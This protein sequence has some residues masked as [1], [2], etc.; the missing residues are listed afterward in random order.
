MESITVPSPE[1]IQKRIAE[2]ED[3]LRTLRRLLR[4]SRAARDAEEAGRRDR[5]AIPQELPHA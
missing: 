4:L 5:S 1:T 3:E 2:C